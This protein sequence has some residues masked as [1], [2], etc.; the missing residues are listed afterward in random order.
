ME[1]VCIFDAGDNRNDLEIRPPELCF[2]EILNERL[3]CQHIGGFPQKNIAYLRRKCFRI[4][5]PHRH[6]G[7]RRQDWP[8][9]FIDERKALFRSHCDPIGGCSDV[10]EKGMV[11]WFSGCLIR[12]RFTVRNRRECV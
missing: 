8:N 3:V 5:E 1:G 10:H 9:H 7:V 2:P 12:H 11:D 4:K 6:F